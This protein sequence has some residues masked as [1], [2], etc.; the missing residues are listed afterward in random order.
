MGVKEGRKLEREGGKE[1]GREVGIVRAKE[2]GVNL[3][4]A[5]ISHV[6]SPMDTLCQTSILY[7]QTTNSNTLGTGWKLRT[8]F[9][10]RVIVV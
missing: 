6:S 1:G 5:T 4:T 2:E 7:N 10:H 3:K 9:D 8:L